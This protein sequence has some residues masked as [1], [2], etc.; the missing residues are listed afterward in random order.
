MFYLFLFSKFSVG[1]NLRLRAKSKA[2]KNYQQNI[3]TMQN[4]SIQ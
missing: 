4:R 2:F 1:S 3:E